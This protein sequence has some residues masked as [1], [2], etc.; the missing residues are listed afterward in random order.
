MGVF[1]R[2]PRALAVRGEQRGLALP[3]TTVIETTSGWLVRKRTL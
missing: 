1:I 3:A 2:T